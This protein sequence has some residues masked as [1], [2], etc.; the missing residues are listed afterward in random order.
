MTLFRDCRD[1]LDTAS[2]LTSYPIARSTLDRTA[3]AAGAADR[4]QR[5][6]D[7]ETEIDA[8]CELAAI[9]PFASPALTER[10]HWRGPA[11]RRYVNEAVRQARYRAAELRALRRE[12]ELLERLLET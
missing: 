12:A 6:H 10:T 7:V 5:M 1:A 2:G 9:G 8:A 4:R 3:L 11:W